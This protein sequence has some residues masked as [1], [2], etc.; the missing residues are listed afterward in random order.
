[1]TLKIG[2]LLAILLLPLLMSCPG[3]GPLITTY[4]RIVIDT[5]EP[6]GGLPMYIPAD[7]FLT[8]YGLKN[9]IW[10]VAASDDDGNQDIGQA[11]SSR[12]ELFDVAPGQYFLKVTKG[13]TSPAGTIGPYAVRVLSVDV[14]AALPGYPP[15][16]DVPSDPY[17]NM[18]APEAAP[19]LSITPVSI[20]LGTDDFGRI[21][22]TADDVD[23]LEITLP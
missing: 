9:S 7:T 15:A 3:G 19:P 23:W 6:Q 21:L 22:D 12:I 8:L 17:E 2:R 11:G 5:Y 10:E 14:G 4:A 20:K 16:F 13:P 1:M 18:D